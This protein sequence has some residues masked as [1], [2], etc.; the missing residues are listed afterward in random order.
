MK[1]IATLTT[2]AALN[3]GAVLQAYALHRYI[4][5]TGCKCD[6]LNYVPEH[7]DKSY[8][9]LSIPKNP[10]GAVMSAFQLLN[11]SQRKLR[12]ERF[13]N[14]RKEYISL[15]G[16]KIRSH[17]RLIEEANSYDMVVCGSDQIWSPV[18]H[19]FDEAYFLSFPEIETRR[20]SYAASFGLDVIDNS[21]KPELKRRLEGFTDFACRENAGKAIIKELTQKDSEMVLDPV[22]LID[23]EEWKKIAKPLNR[24]KAFNLAYFL[25][26][27]GGS[28]F[29]LKKYSQKSN[30]EVLSI[31]FSPRDFRYGIECDYS[32]GPCE[33]L[34][35]VASAEFILTNSFHCT[36]FAILF[37]KNFYTRV[38]EAK[39]S[40][41]D[42]MITLLKELGLEDRIYVDSQAD[43]LDFDK[44]IDYYAVNARLE[45]KKQASK[46]YLNNII[47]NLE[48]K[49]KFI[50]T[51]GDCCACGACMSACPVQAIRIEKNTNGFYYP[52]INDGLCVKCEKCKTVCP[53]NSRSDGEKWEDGD[54]YALWADDK[55]QRA[56]GSSGGAFGL[57]ADNVIESG[58]VVFGA[59]YS[60]DFRTVYQTS[61]DKAE[62]GALKKSKYVESYTGT[63][64]REVKAA[65]EA[66]KEVLYC[67]TSCQIDGLINYLDKDYDNLLTCDFLCHGVPSA[68]VYEKYI[69]NLES[70]FGKVVNVDFR[71]KAYGWKAYCSKVEFESKKTYLKTLYQDPYLRLFFEN[72]VL[73]DSC[74]SCKR[75]NNS[76]ADI[77]LGDFWRAGQTKIHDSNEGISLVGVH[78]EKGQKR[79]KDLISSGVCTVHKLERS[80]YDYAYKRNLKKPFNRNTEMKK[81][82]E[83]TDLFGIAVSFKTKL[84]GYYYFGKAFLDKMQIK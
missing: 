68:G 61:T 76:N 13:E 18:L 37:G 2:H 65:L 32:L 10:Q 9:L 21:F 3:Y 67:G 84:K 78:S 73:R 82:T 36:A 55:L 75:L 31:G 40:R 33:F 23:A 57:L 46:A 20:V 54:F 80:D 47:A 34:N 50:I 49:E 77:T 17:K 12:K 64:F 35:A 6:V 69:T 11:Y 8:E 62:L 7:V 42:R 28:P 72:N 79:V 83:N 38:S 19:G 45:E 43:S 53:V 48:T 29:A 63:V 66:G 16:E 4:G 15:S 5:S 52:S 14:F 58:G 26:N 56:S 60:D 22:F 51:E 39:G 27:P 74:Y 1:H 41:N 71:S 24:N 25:S 59:A 81:I 70:R 30:T 44:K